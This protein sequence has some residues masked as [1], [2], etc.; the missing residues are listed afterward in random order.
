MNKPGRRME[1]IGAVERKLAAD[2]NNPAAK[3]YAR[4]STRS[5]RRASSSPR[6]RRGKP[7]KDFDYE[8]VEQLGC[9]LVDDAD[10]ERRERGMG[11]LRMAGRGLADRAPGIFKKLAEV[12][13]Q[14]RRP[15][16]RQELR[17]KWP[18]RSASRSGPRNLAPDQW[19]SLSRRAPQARRPAPISAAI[20]RRAI[21]ELPRSTRRIAARRALET[22]RKLAELYGKMPTTGEQGGAQRPPHDRERPRLQQH[23]RRPPEEARQLLLL[24][25]TR[26]TRRSRRTWSRSGSTWGTA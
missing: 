18:S 21:D 1:A 26:A 4:C 9:A 13:E 17:S 11:Y 24:A 20:T 2:P 25:R 14:A 8:Y 12:Y 16:E 23:R 19:N 10:P 15:G 5:F 7:P 22:Y 6:W 3:E